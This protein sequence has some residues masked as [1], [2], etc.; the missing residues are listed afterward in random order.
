MVGRANSLLQHGRRS[1][2][3]STDQLLLRTFSDALFSKQLVHTYQDAK[4]KKK[5]V[6]IAL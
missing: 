2:L 6:R 3:C 5:I 4:E 1:P